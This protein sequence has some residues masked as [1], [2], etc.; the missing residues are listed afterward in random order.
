MVN[1]RSN[2]LIIV[3]ILTL[4][5]FSANVVYAACSTA[6]APGPLGYIIPAACLQEQTEGCP[7]CGL[8]EMVLIAINI[9]K[10]ILATLGSATLVVVIYG[11]FVW[12]TSAGNSQRVEHGKKVFEGA[13]IGF[14]VV[15][16]SWLIINFIIAALTGQSPAGPAQLF[17]NQK[18]GGGSTGQPAFETPK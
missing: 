2:I 5:M 4:T 12:L 16:G 13:L 14:A 3:A 6:P 10:I 7:P 18:A 17:F 8:N 9:S 11:G 15:L 1:Q